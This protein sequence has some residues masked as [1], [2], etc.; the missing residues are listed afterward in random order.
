MIDEVCK[1]LTELASSCDDEHNSRS[2]DNIVA[3]C[4]PSDLSR[5][6][7][8]WSKGAALGLEEEERME[9]IKVEM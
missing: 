4:K 6:L 2:H 3:S 9:A 8:A 5:S 1:R 7:E